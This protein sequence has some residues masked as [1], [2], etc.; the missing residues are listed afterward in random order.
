MENRILDLD[1]YIV[2]RSIYEFPEGVKAVLSK[3]Y[4]DIK[5][6]KTQGKAPV[7]D[8]NNYSDRIN[9]IPSNQKGDCRPLLVGVC[10]DK[11][12]FENRMLE[13]LDH[14][15]ITCASINREVFFF[16]TQ[17]NSYVANKYRGY[18]QSVKRSGVS[19]NMIYVTNVGIALMPV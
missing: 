11:D 12:H 17:W 14:A 13:C 3:I 5:E 4:D 10:Y 7:D 18:I 2:Q 19:I 9:L 6:E 15:S 1:K 8:G 16:T